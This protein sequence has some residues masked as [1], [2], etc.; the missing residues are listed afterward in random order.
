[1]FAQGLYLNNSVPDVMRKPEPL[2]EV[3]VG[4][5]QMFEDNHDTIVTVRIINTITLNDVP[6]SDTPSATYSGSSVL[7]SAGSIPS[8]STSPGNYG[9]ALDII[10]TPFHGPHKV[11][12]LV[13]SKANP[14]ALSRCIASTVTVTVTNPGVT[15]TVFANSVVSGLG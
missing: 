7:N 15:T 11:V 10:P 13:G 12:K 14:I 6:S 2:K 9:S 1:M 3:Q 4:V 5:K 8:T